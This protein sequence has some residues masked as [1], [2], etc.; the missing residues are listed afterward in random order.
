MS[1]EQALQVLL[2]YENSLNGLANI[3]PTKEEFSQAVVIVVSLLR[4]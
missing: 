2:D 4:T 3:K 1:K